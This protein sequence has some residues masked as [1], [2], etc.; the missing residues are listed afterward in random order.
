M[1]P[2]AAA[3]FDV[4]GTLVDSTYLHT[5]TWSEALR[6]YGH[7]VP[8]SRVHRAIGLGTDKLLD[9]LLGAE[10]DRSGDDAMDA[11]HLALY[12]ARWPS[13]RRLPGARRLLRACA[14]RG[15]SVV[16]ATSA[17]AREVEVLRRVLDA[18]DAI[19]QHVDADAVDAAKPAP[20]LV[21]RALEQ[22]GV[23]SGR[24]VFIGDTAWDVQAARKAGV[25]CL[26]VMTGGWCRGELED[27]GAAQVYRDAAEIAD[28][29]DAS[30]L[31]DPAALT[32]P[33]SM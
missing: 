24:A 21:Q 26:G 1:T 27:A 30:L 9:H 19:A 18:D 12:A 5:V 13:L 25:P 6:Q 22:A 8:M 7:D 29:L 31:A 4:D 15:W 3:L 23:S 28:Y 14:E 33:V 2:Q 16:L 17:S 32:P 11:A 20:D 10:R